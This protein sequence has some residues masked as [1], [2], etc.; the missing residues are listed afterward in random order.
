M[1]SKTKLEHLH[2]LVS[3]VSRKRVFIEENLHNLDAF[4]MF[5]Q[6][7]EVCAKVWIDEDMFESAIEEKYDFPEE[8]ID[9]WLKVFFSYTHQLNEFIYAFKADHWETQWEK[10]DYL[11]DGLDT[12]L[13]GNEEPIEE[14]D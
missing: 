14:E 13:V 3:F 1:D 4:F 9:Q 7:K 12:K 11:D 10:L 6:A 2:N 5:R 8:E